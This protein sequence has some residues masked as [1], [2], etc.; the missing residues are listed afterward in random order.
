[1][2]PLQLCL[3]SYD[4]KKRRR[5]GGTEG[6][7]MDVFCVLIDALTRPSDVILKIL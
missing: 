1:M 5:R 4:E 2:S 3:D 6:L 7:R